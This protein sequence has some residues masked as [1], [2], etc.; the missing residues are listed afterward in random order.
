MQFQDRIC[1]KACADTSQ[2]MPLL[3]RAW[4]RHG[5]TWAQK[6]GCTQQSL[7]R[8]PPAALELVELF[9]TPRI[10]LMLALLSASKGAAFYQNGL[11]DLSQNIHMC[12]MGSGRLLCSVATN[13]KIF[14]CA[15]KEIL[16]PHHLAAV[17]GFS[18]EK[19]K[20][21]YQLGE[22]KA[23]FARKLGGNSMHV[24]TIAVAV[25]ALLSAVNDVQ[26]A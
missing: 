14:L 11:V 1:Y 4:A 2:D 15:R 3:R 13:S 17:L 7:D 9:E 18:S 8:L 20:A 16:S 23:T 21:L 5:Q 10:R 22:R 19:I 6:H 24:P 12:Q 25:W 26:A